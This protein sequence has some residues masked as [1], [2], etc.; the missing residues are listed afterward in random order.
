MYFHRK[1]RC[2]RKG[3]GP[4]AVTK[5]V[6]YAFRT[7]PFCCDVSRAGISV[8]DRHWSISSPAV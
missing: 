6:T 4:S 3:I 5:S 1:T 7:V 2:I 8:A